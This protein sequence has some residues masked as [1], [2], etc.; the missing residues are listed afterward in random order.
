MRNIYFTNIVLQ[1]KEIMSRE[2]EGSPQP[3]DIKMLTDMLETRFKGMWGKMLAD[4]LDPI[5][6]KLAGSNS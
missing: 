4:A 5:H 6:E 2:S 3:I 1:V